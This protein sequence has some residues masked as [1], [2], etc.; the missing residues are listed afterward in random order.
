MNFSDRTYVDIVRDLLTVLTGGTVSEVHSIG[1]EVPELI[2]LDNRPVKRISF[3]KGQIKVGDTLT[4]YTFNEKDFE[5]TGTPENPSMLAAIR[6]RPRAHLPAPGTQLIV[7]YYPARLKPTPLSDINVGSVART[8]IETMSRELAV[9]YQQLQKV[10]DSAFVETAQGSSLD[11]IGSLLDTFRITGGTAV[12]TVRFSRKS[13]SPGTI[14]IPQKTVVSDGAGTRYETSDEAMLLPSQAST[15]VWVHGQTSAVAPV[16][17][18]ALTV[19]ERAIAG[20]ERVVNDA[21]TYRATEDEADAQYAGRI[22]RAIHVSGKGTVDAL[23]Y[24]IEALDCVSSV[25]ISEYPDPSVPMPGMMRIDVALAQESDINKRLVDRRIEELRPAGIYVDRYWAARVTLGFTVA[26]VLKG[27]SASAADIDDVQ[28]GIG[29]R[30]VSYVQTLGPG[31]TLRKARLISLI[32]EDPLVADATVRI[33][34]DGAEISGDSWVL[35]DNKV[36]SVDQSNPVTFLPAA[37]ESAAAQAAVAIQLHAY[38]VTSTLAITADA[39]KTQLRAALTTFAAT[40]NPSTSVTFDQLAAVI[41]KDA[42]FTLDRAGS[43]FTFEQ[44]GG[45]STEVRD[46]GPAFT[47]PPLFNLTVGTIET[48]EASA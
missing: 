48:S 13:G 27:S 37:F 17:K 20:I 14:Y 22:R 41:R 44:T 15:E 30:F 38:C 31:E 21:P 36:A 3:L 10:Y 23:R 46:N 7:N 34:A 40:L 45:M 8:L 18:G 47:L 29:E 1:A 28:D 24:G 39:L 26:L 42:A 4:D 43:I 16:G 12:G 5:L 19:L 9:Q 25:G 2:Y 32:L 6:F 11:K 33:S 35:P